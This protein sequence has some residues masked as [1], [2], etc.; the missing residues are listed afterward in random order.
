MCN[1]F[2]YELLLLLKI[3]CILINIKNL[4]KGA[5]ATVNGSEN[6][7]RFIKMT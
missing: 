5:S 6:V 7:K 4:I 1:N 3:I 2:K